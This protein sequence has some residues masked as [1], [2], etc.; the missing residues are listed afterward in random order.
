M[1]DTIFYYFYDFF[2]LCRY[3]EIFYSLFHENM[4]MLVI[5]RNKFFLII[6][7]SISISFLFRSDF[8]ELNTIFPVLEEFVFDI[9][10]FN[11]PIGY[12]IVYLP[13]EYF[14]ID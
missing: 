12:N 6:F 1:L 13:Y 9:Y 2:F 10:K 14:N 11:K 3:H 8:C 4:K 5:Y 7:I